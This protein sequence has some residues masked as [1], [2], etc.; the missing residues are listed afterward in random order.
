MLLQKKKIS[1][2]GPEKT[3]GCETAAGTCFST[4]TFTN[5]NK[6]C[7]NSSKSLCVVA[8]MCRLCCFVDFFSTESFYSAALN[9]NNLP[10]LHLTTC[11]DDFRDSSP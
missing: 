9:I 2:C 7:R 3:V 5:L 11:R 4:L 8:E 1:I 6:E 10:E